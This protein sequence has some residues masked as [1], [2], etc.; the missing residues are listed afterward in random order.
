MSDWLDIKCSVTYMK[1]LTFKKKY[2]KINMKIRQKYYY[3]S[4]YKII[5]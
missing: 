5:G 1:L 2:K 3:L 4:A